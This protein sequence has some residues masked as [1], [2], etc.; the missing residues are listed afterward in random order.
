MCILTCVCSDDPVHTPFHYV[1]P[2]TEHRYETDAYRL[3]LFALRHVCLEQQPIAALFTD[4]QMEQLSTLEAFCDQPDQ[5]SPDQWNQQIQLVFKLLLFS[6]HD[7]IDKRAHEDPISVFLILIHINKYTG[8][9]ASC[10]SIAGSLSGLQ[11]IAR[12]VAV[13]EILSLDNDNPRPDGIAM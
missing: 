3:L 9:F 5:L 12:L 10:G 4:K 13:R 7:E 2:S 8:S 11:H 1:G 6:M